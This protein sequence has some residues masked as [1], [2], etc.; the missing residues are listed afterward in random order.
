M[1]KH[2]VWIFGLTNCMISVWCTDFLSECMD[3]LRDVW[4]FPWCMG[5]SGG[6]GVKTRGTGLCSFCVTHQP[7]QFG[8]QR[9]FV[10][11]NYLFFLKSI[12]ND[13]LQITNLII[14]V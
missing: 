1:S 9:G 5:V 6:T 10:I 4:I 14:T 8:V 13:L 12:S 11:C 7:P 3:L 2:G